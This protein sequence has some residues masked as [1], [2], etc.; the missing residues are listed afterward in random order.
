VT[1]SAGTLLALLSLVACAGVKAEHT[2][3]QTGQGG[4]GGNGGSPFGTAGSSGPATGAAGTSSGGPTGVCRKLQCQQAVC[5]PG[6][7]TTVTGMVY[8]PAGKV[9]LFNIIVYVPNDPLDPITEGVSCDKCAG[10]ASGSPVASALTD[11]TG[12]FVLENVPAG[13]AIPLVIQIGKWRREVTIPHVAPCADT[14]LTDRELTRLPR[15]QSEGHLPQMALTTG[16][17]DALEC[18]LRKIGI[19]DHEF[20]APTGTGRVHMY[21][22]CDGGSGTG[23]DHFTPALGGGT[24]PAA[25][26]LWGNPTTLAKYDMLVL[27]CESSQCGSAKRPFIANVKAYADMGGRL[28]LDHLH[29]YWLRSGTTPWPDTATYVGT[30]TDLPSPFTSKID[31]SFP[32][33]MS[34]ADWLVNVGATPTKGQIS[35]LGGQFSVEA[36]LPPTTQQWIYTDANPS[37]SAHTAVEY[38]TMNTPSELA[39][40]APQ[41]QCGR[42]VYTDLHVVSASTDKSDAATPFPSGCVAAELTPQ[43]KAL[44]FMLFDLSSC[45]QPE[46][47]R[48]APPIVE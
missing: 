40:T 12:T 17:A 8:D 48:P 36:A 27:S 42:V 11:A 28:F 4:Q 15:T 26:T 13:D 14:A 44:E 3:I 30:G 34:F 21:V 29:F 2:A 45:V 18:L 10:T 23:A 39:L 24:F 6:Q 9:P 46:K 5:S 33:G 20:T 16:H 22:G 37:G 7:K 19:D 1:R 38:M 47:M 43:E 25:D 31:T 41:N 32:K 35:I